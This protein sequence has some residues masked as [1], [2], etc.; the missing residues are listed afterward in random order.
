MN[1]L[2]IGL[3]SIGQ[4]H[5]RNLKKLN[6]KIKFFA[7]REKNNSPLLSDDNQVLNKKFSLEKNDIT[8]I[9]H[10]SKISEFKIDAML[11][12]IPSSLHYK[13]INIALSK[14]M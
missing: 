5:F 14:G 9:P 7:Y 4:R 8:S 2:I 13:F 6:K 10:I 3:G 11:I 1:F 12:C